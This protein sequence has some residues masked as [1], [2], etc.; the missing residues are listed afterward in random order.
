MFSGEFLLS[1]RE[2]F[3]GSLGRW[4]GKEN[5][6]ENKKFGDKTFIWS[7]YSDLTRVFTPNGGF[8]KGN[9][10]ISGKSG[11]VKYYNLTRLIPP[12][13]WSAWGWL[14]VLREP[15]TPFRGLHR[16]SGLKSQLS[17]RAPGDECFLAG[18]FK[19]FLYSP[20]FGEMIQFD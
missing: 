10:L 15:V 16:L 17:H 5:M 7:N 11:L 9:P 1:L 20:L 19:C 2:G 3:L 6:L 8:S 13:V 12:G 14:N 18:G 4:K